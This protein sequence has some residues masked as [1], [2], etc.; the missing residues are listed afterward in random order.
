[1]LPKSN[2]LP[3]VVVFNNSQSFVTPF[4][5]VLYKENE[6]DCNRFGFV[7][8]KHVDKRATVRNRLKRILREVCLQYLQTNHHRDV[9]FIVK[10]NFEQESI[11]SIKEIIAKEFEN[12]L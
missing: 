7:V 10:K 4:F 8:S 2:R 11:R 5:R 1:M 3:H 6:L 12:I 9:L